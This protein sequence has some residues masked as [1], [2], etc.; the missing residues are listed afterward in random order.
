MTDRRGNETDLRGTGMISYLGQQARSLDK[1]KVC[2]GKMKLLV[3]IHS[4]WISNAIEPSLVYAPYTLI[5][6][7]PL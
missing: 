6:C 1:R 4:R 5:A 7:K 3:E 2:R